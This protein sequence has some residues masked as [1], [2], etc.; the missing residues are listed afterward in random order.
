MT[1]ICEY[2]LALFTTTSG[3][4]ILFILFLSYPIKVNNQDLA[5]LD[6]PSPRLVKE[7]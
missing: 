7:G 6:P 2:I 5:L 1:E 4:Y 3:S